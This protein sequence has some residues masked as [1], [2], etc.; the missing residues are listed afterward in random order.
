MA[1]AAPQKIIVF[2]DL[3]PVIAGVVAE[4]LQKTTGIMVTR[5]GSASPP[6]LVICGPSLSPLPPAIPVI[7][8][9]RAQRLGNLLAAIHRALEEPALAVRPFALG[10]DAFYPAEK[11]I[12]CA[13]A[14]EVLLT[15][16]ETALLLCLARHAPAAVSR[17]TLLQAVWSYQS[18]IDTHTLETHVYRLRQKI[19]GAEGAGPLQTT[20]D[21]YVLTG[22][23]ALPVQADPLDDDSV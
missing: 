3:D 1:A 12:I 5:D 17:E 18:G 21:G 16:R 6:H 15:E 20:D 14:A 19:G 9:G 4:Q 8:L 23:S 10:D 11:K 13:D 22:V 7:R 2:Q